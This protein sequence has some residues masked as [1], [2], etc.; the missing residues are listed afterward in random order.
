MRNTSPGKFKIGFNP[1]IADAVSAKHEDGN[2]RAAVRILSSTDK[3][4]A[5]SAESLQTLTEKH[6]AASVCQPLPDPSSVIA[7]GVD[8][9]TLNKA[10]KSFPNG[11]SGDPDGFRPQHLKAWGVIHKRS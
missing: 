11:S 8:E 6:L 2:I 3:P 10:I 9:A 1:P 7:V 5:A 4:V